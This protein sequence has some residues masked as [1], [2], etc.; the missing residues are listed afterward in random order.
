MNSDLQ[1]LQPYPFE[2]LAKLKAGVTPPTEL[3]HIALSI[4]EP[5]HPSPA[6]V[7]DEL[8]RNL[9]KL[10][11]YPTTAGT[12]ELRQTIADW[13]TRRFKLQAGSL[14]GA[15]NVLPALGTR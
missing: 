7:I 13:A 4:G 3:E 11:N 14:T 5:K 2:K 10:A 6:F 15:D 8:S 1:K 9:D 12:I